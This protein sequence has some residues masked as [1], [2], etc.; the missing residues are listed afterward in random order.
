M[1]PQNHCAKIEIHLNRL[2]LKENYL[3]IYAQLKEKK[4]G[5]VPTMVMSQC[6]KS[7]KSDLIKKP[8]KLDICPV[9]ELLMDCIY[10]RTE[11]ACGKAYA[12][13]VQ[14]VLVIRYDDPCNSNV[15][16]S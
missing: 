7:L 5:K 8:E 2:K 14:K 13:F 3:G 6:V 15:K 12:K 16:D 11:R 1:K 9:F 4:V 10:V